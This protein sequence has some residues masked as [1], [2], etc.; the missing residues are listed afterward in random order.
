MKLRIVPILFLTLL[1]VWNA[2][3]QDAVSNAQP[4]M[5]FESIIYDFGTIQEEN[6]PVTHDFTFQNTG[7]SDLKIDSVKA[8]CGCTTPGWTQ[9]AI[10]PS[11]SGAVTAR[12]DPKNRP[13][14]FEKYLTVF[15]NTEQRITQLLIK[16][17]VLPRPKTIV[18]TLVTKIGALRVKSQAFNFETITTEKPVTKVF[19]MYN[20]ST[21]AFSFL[22]PTNL[23]PH[24][25]LSIEPMTLEP[26]TKGT[27]TVTFD[28][29]IK[30]DYGHVFDY[31]ILNTN[32]PQS[33]SKQMYTVATI[34]EYFPPMTEKELA[35][36]PIIAFEKLEHHFGDVPKGQ[37][38]STTFSF[39][40]TGKSDLFIRKSKASCGCT[41][42]QPDK[43]QLKPG[44]T[45]TITV[46]YNG[47]GKGEITKK[48]TI[49]SNAPG[50]P[51]Q[52]LLIKANVL[53]E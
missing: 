11:T 22:E 17:E 34:E 23:P 36:A 1:I 33:A 44:E 2:R 20:D 5:T 25:Q 29:K 16:G 53:V 24:V 45:G 46:T 47:S 8:S 40:N 30:N 41:A 4:V 10:A 39:T 48:V 14:K 35:N 19:E 32:E 28:P 31:I 12:F 42:S 13:G 49:Y 6:G 51:I 9:T 27:I 21:A 50:N 52:G 26:K 43:T 7:N 18:D 15:S 3:A 37:S 38:V